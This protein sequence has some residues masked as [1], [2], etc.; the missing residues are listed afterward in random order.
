MNTDLAD[1]RFAP[2]AHSKTFNRIL[3]VLALRDKKVLDFGCGFGEYLVKFGKG[4][5]GLTTTLEEVEYGKLKNIRIVRGNVE[6]IDALNLGETFDALWANNLFE[7]LVAPHAFLIKLKTISKHDTLLVLGVP[8]VP[9]I[10][11]LLKVHKFR[12]ALAVAHVNFFTRETLRLSVQ[13]AG[14][15]VV[16]VR[17]FIFKNR[18]LDMLC[19]FF[20]PHLY[21]VAR[22]NSSF[23]YADKKL[24][25]WK[26]DSHY[27]DILRIVGQKKS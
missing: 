15:N 7:H 2:V 14:W 17:P 1:K 11:S 10:A 9:R 12:G 5:L 19:S 24:K 18:F 8:V 20:A 26:D 23:T 21:V 6:L 25:E 3:D 13:Y 27:A 22:N 4:S 16:D